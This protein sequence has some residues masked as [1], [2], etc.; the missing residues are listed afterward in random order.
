MNAL[1]KKI[2]RSDMISANDD[3]IN[4]VQEKIRS[5]TEVMGRK[6]AQILKFHNILHFLLKVL[7]KSRKLP[8]KNLKIL[9]QSR[10]YFF[11]K[12][13]GNA[14]KSSFYYKKVFF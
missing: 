13:T 10:S 5:E 2:W 1:K 12:K 9:K 11:Y 14:P 4:F 6:R 8:K 3:V 7:I